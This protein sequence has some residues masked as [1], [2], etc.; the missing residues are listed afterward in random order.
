MLGRG[1]FF[2]KR[3]IDIERKKSG[4]Q[5]SLQLLQ[6]NKHENNSEGMSLVLNLYRSMYFKIMILKIIHHQ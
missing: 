3:Y 6:P 1:C 5:E 2:K 4:D